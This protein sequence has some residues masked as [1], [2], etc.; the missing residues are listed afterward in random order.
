M[1]P[2]GVN[3]SRD[4]TVAVAPVEKDRMLA[5]RQA[6]WQRIRDGVK[7]LKLDDSSGL[8]SA[9]WCFIGIAGGACVSVLSLVGAKPEN[10]SAWLY[11]VLVS[12]LFAS[13]AIAV[14]CAVAGGKLKKAIKRDAG[15]LCS[16]MDDLS[17]SILT[18]DSPH[19]ARPASAYKGVKLARR[20]QGPEQIPN[21]LETLDGQS[22]DEK[23]PERWLSLD[24]PRVSKK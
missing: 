5:V 22:L 11:P 18:P 15:Q 10:V 23:V 17:D 7:S 20:G 6:D 3:L 16:E 1:N 2:E 14:A 8:R 21:P 9:S 12:V 24:K 4:V 19:G 13:L